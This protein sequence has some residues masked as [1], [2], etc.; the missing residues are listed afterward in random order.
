MR[1]EEQNDKILKRIQALGFTPYP[2]TDPKDFEANSGRIEPLTEFKPDDWLS[3]N[4]CEVI[5][6]KSDRTIYRWQTVGGLINFT[7]EAEGTDRNLVRHYIFKNDFLKYM[8]DIAKQNVVYVYENPMTGETEAISDKTTEGKFKPVSADMT[9]RQERQKVV[10]L[11]QETKEK[12]LGLPDELSKR[13]KEA[14]SHALA[15]QKEELSKE[16]NKFDSLL[17][18]QLDYKAQTETEKVDMQKGFSRTIVK[19]S[20]FNISLIVIIVAAFSGLLV[21]QQNRAK[22]E[23]EAL[24]NKLTAE[25]SQ[26]LDKDLTALKTDLGTEYSQKLDAVST[27]VKS[28][29]ENLNKSLSTV[30]SSLNQANN[31]ISSVQDSLGSLKKRLN[32]KEEPINETEEDTVLKKIE[33]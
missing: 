17:T 7:T 11:D 18:K 13:L 21:W 5:A 4:Q 20:T 27:T 10:N 32:I 14:F 16:L 9:I 26:K 12:M 8:Q 28:D 22:L 31:S 15:Q 3:I 2:Y 1:N 33:E 6:K 25:Y 24:E 30:S 19:F 29:F 23:R